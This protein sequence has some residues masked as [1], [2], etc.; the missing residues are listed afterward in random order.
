MKT[1][2]ILLFLFFTVTSAFAQEKLER[3]Y[4]IKQS[5]V[6]SKALDFVR[7]S[8]GTGKIKWY[9]EDNLSG[10]AIEAKG[11]QGGNLY[12]VK[13]NTA[14]DL[15]DVEVVVSFNNLPETTRKAIATQLDLNFSKYRIQKT[16]VQWLADSKVLSSLIRQEPAPGK[17][18]INYE[19]T[20]RGT[21]N[22]QTGYY[23]FLMDENGK[24]IRTS[25][26]IE[27]NSHNLIY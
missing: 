21:K 18:V 7:S 23:E 13:F 6:P 9:G 27:R 16:Q 26:I 3:E 24:V 22:R 12:S 15:Q 2:L 8:F 4:R 1:Q 11:K 10:K 25:T 5:E 20:V 17:H 14:G 19:I